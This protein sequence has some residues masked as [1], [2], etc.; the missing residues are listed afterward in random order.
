V[1]ALERL[2]RLVD[3]SKSR[4]AQEC[5]LE[6]AASGR[7]PDPND[8]LALFRERG[9]LSSGEG[10]AGE[11]DVEVTV[12]TGDAETGT[13]LRADRRRA[14]PTN[15]GSSRSAVYETF[16]TRFDLLGQIG[17]GSMGEVLL[18]KDQD[19]RRKVAYKRLRAELTTQPELAQRFLAEA[20]ITAQLD[21]PNVVPLYSLEHEEAHG[22]GYVMKLVR[23]KTLAALIKE[24]RSAVEAGQPPS[25]RAQRETLLDHFLKVCDAIAF[26]HARGV[27]HRDLKPANI[28][29]GRF[30]EVYVMDWGIAR[31]LDIPEVLLEGREESVHSAAG[32]GAHTTRWGT[33]LGTPRYM[34]PEQARGEIDRLDR[35]S[36]LYSLGLMLYELVCLRPA[37]S[38]PDVSSLM[39]RVRRGQRARI[40]APTRS[41]KIASEL[42]AIIDKATR[43]APDDRYPDVSAFAHDLRN[44][45]RG[46]A[47]SAMRDN[48]LHR[49]LRWI[50]HHREEALNLF[51]ATLLI[52]LVVI[53]TL[54]YRH[55]VTLQRVA[56]RR[57]LIS[58]YLGLASRRAQGITHYFLSL[59][60]LLEG[61]SVGAERALGYDL[62]GT[63]KYYTNGDFAERAGA[64]P[65]TRPIAR[66][67]GATGEV[68][69]VSTDFPVVVFPGG[70]KMGSGV[71]RKVRQL[72]PLNDLFWRIFLEAH[73]E[74][75]VP[76]SG[77]KVRAVLE[78]K[79]LVIDWAAVALKDGAMIAYPGFGGFGSDYEPTTRP[80]Y[81]QA[82][83]AEGNKVCGEPYLG[84]VRRVRFVPCSVAL[85]T[86]AGDFLGV[87]TLELPL[88]DGV[89][90]LLLAPDL[91][92]VRALLLNARGEILV[93]ASPSG[94]DG[95][96]AAMTQLV[97]YPHE[98]VVEACEKGL[99]GLQELVDAGRKL[100]VIHL[101]LP[102]LRWTYVAEL[103][104]QG[105][106]EKLWG[107][108]S[109]TGE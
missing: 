19:L 79:A 87:A 22:L 14:G 8:L 99:S 88:A 17:A 25:A 70:K 39:E 13:V 68:L 73:G 64:P 53:G 95:A 3:P 44:Y 69:D 59:Q 105:P 89:R 82:V 91:P 26:A 4:Q 28:M 103:P 34:S 58:S 7:E 32:V 104:A 94:G 37:F 20:Q 1:K 45:L 27:I 47:V 65:D 96:D 84:K 92:V 101:Y 42:A 10:P 2:L 75:D 5:Y 107:L 54:W 100:W 12:L 86:D 71:E 24:A 77:E 31:V 102:D 18:A 55:E 67:R 43:V 50:G 81:Q 72:L 15:R 40:A 33:L 30:N 109:E 61:L 9:L 23:G 78:Q 49:A 97:V 93:Q 56:E 90:K 16:R 35:R 85:Y 52:G 21:H 63:R 36:D 6:L 106:A 80:W 57:A 74:R 46:E 11:G 38:A 60:G 76:A 98:R 29:V 48:A 108:T 66:Y 51:L 83:A 41:L 62:P